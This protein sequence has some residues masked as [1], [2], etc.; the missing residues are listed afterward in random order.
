M[1]SVLLALTLDTWR[2]ERRQHAR[3]EEARAS[4]AEEVALNRAAIAADKHLAYHR[5]YR[6]YYQS[7]VNTKATE[8]AGAIFDGGLHPAPLRDTAWQSMVGSDVA[9]LLPFGQRAELAAIYKDQADLEALFR[10]VLAGLITPRSDR[11]SPAYLRDQTL[12]LSLT[13]TDMV[14]IEE[15]LLQEY[16]KAEADLRRATP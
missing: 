6:D 15:R 5:H 9:S 2:D 8:G 4:V 11:E 13:L 3:L 14:V 12:V 7:L 10:S 1:F 16:Q